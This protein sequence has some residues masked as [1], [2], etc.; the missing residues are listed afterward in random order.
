MIYTYIKKSPFSFNETLD[1]LRIAFAAKWFGVVSNVDIAKRVRKNIDLDFG[2][3]T[4]LWFCNPMLAH[5]YLETDMNLWI[6]M[7]CTV[8]VY[9]KNNEVF[10]SAGLPE[11]VIS[12]VI[13][14][15]DLEDLHKEIS[16]TM[17]K[18]IDSIV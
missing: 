7:P 13:E 17:K 15:N 9:E 5:K 1:E 3:Y 6:F 11:I 8:S 18:V 14:N 12:K 4:N 16:D 10:I 2:E